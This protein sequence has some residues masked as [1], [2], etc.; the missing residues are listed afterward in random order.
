MW[1]LL[2]VALCLLRH[3]LLVIFLTFLLCYVVRHIVDAVAGRFWRNQCR[4]WRERLLIAGLFALL[5]AGV[6]SAARV[7]GP[8]ALAECLQLAER[9]S[10]MDPEYEFHQ[11][12]NRTVGAYAFQEKY[13]DSGSPQ[14]QSAYRQFVEK[15]RQVSVAYDEFPTV[16]ALVA[17]TVETS[18]RSAGGASAS[19]TFAALASN[20]TKWRSRRA[21]KPRWP[22]GSANGDNPIRNCILT[23]TTPT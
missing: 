16:E 22:N 23:P 14:Y 4:P 9:V 20:W 13:G 21:F 7:L 2:L 18:L 5:F 19:G 17:R 1:A 12:L 10:K 11:A 6:Y 15:G 3:L 8:F